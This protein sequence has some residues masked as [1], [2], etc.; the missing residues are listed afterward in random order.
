MQKPLMR[1]GT[2]PVATSDER[3]MSLHLSATNHS[4]QALDESQIH[5]YLANTGG[6]GSCRRCGKEQEDPIHDMNNQADERLC[7]ICGKRENLHYE[8][9]KDKDLGHHFSAK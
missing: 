1:C 3:A 8:H 5:Q 9:G 2:C 6:Y 7:S 4:L